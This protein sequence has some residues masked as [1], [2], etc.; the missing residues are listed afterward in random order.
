MDP[1][2]ISAGIIA[3]LQALSSSAK[4]AMELWNAPQELKELIEELEQVAAVAENINGLTASHQ[5]DTIDV[6]LCLARAR[7]KLQDAQSLVVNRL[8]QNQPGSTTNARARFKR[9]T[10]IRE[11]GRVKKLVRDLKSVRRDL[12]ATLDL[13]NLL[14]TKRS[15]GVAM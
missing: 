4:A 2:S 14:V 3:V 7:A 12:S 11:R 9:S 8:T 1:L 15:N 10:Y 5:F 13:L 6:T